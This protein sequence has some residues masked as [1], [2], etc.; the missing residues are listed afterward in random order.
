MEYLTQSPCIPHTDSTVRRLLTPST[1]VVVD[2]ERQPSPRISVRGLF[3]RCLYE[4]GVEV[5][6]PTRLAP[7]GAPFN[8]AWIKQ[9]RM[10]RGSREGDRAEQ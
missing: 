5:S 3:C 2:G 1:S 9:C 6:L 10:I 7:T 8:L 4:E